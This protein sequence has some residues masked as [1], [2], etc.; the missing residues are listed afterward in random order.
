WKAGYK[1]SSSE[2]ITTYTAID[3]TLK[4]RS[5]VIKKQQNKVKLILI[6]NYTKTTLLGKALYWTT[7]ELSYVP[8]SMYR[9]Q[10][11]QYVR[12]RGINNY[13]IRGL[14]N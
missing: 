12:T 6:Y 2:G 11:R 10:K 13:F 5:I 1:A 4:T 8:D 9:I 3:S 7:E 14:F